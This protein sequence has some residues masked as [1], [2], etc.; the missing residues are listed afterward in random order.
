MCGG[1]PPNTTC[2]IFMIR[3]M[4]ALVLDPLRGNVPI[5][6]S[7]V[8]KYLKNFNGRLTKCGLQ[9]PLSWKSYTGS[10]PSVP[11]QRNAIDCGLYVCIYGECLAR[12]LC[13]PS[14]SLLNDELRKRMRIKIFLQICADSK[15]RA[16]GR[17]RK[18]TEPPSN[19]V[20]LVTVS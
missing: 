10:I 15:I 1:L 7:Y 16:Q 18:R 9:E 5:N 2:W 17:K 12:K 4:E 8:Q 11:I 20:E 19:E 6:E 14:T 3:S 13:F